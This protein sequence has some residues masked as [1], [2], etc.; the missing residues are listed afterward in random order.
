MA[1]GRELREPQLRG[2]PRLQ[3]LAAQQFHRLGRRLGRR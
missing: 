3:A 2:L 1:L